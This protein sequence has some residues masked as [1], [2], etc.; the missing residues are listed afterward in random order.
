MSWGS[1]VGARR[2]RALY[3]APVVAALIVVLD[4]QWVIRPLS[5][6]GALDAVNL[7]RGCAVLTLL[8]LGALY[9]LKPGWTTSNREVRLLS[10]FGA[11]VWSAFAALIYS[12]FLAFAYAMAFIG[13]LLS[14][15]GCT[16][17]GSDEIVLREI[18]FVATGMFVLVSGS[19]FF[20]P[21]AW[22]YDVSRGYRF[23]GFSSPTHVGYVSAV[24]SY[25]WYVYGREEIFAKKST[26]CWMLRWLIVLLGI[27]LV[28]AS[29]TRTALGVFAFGLVLRGL[30]GLRW[31][32]AYRAAAVTAWLLGIWAVGLIAYRD[33]E[34]IDALTSGRVQLWFEML[35]EVSGDRV[36]LMFGLASKVVHMKN[37][38]TPEG[39]WFATHAHNMYLQALWLAGV[40]GFLLMS[41]AMG[42]AVWQFARTAQPRWAMEIG[43]LVAMIGAWEPVI[44]GVNGVMTTLFVGVILA[45]G[46]D[47]ADAK[48]KSIRRG[49]VRCCLSRRR[50]GRVSSE[51]SERGEGY[52]MFEES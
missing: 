17:T 11:G 27:V 48:I 21:E 41:V 23:R 10:L 47:R 28:L 6:R 20:Q 7:V 42:V 32:G 50:V 49:S 30:L 9:I 5:E 3:A 38:T 16:K 52:S 37:W 15:A 2:L 46:E 19:L 14:L 39:D 22:V 24:A 25:L 43:A 33:V 18:V 13:I 29:Q 34:A 8:T 4:V 26:V 44:G 51:S 31:T 12:D 35:Q 40:P 36:N 1:G 45:P